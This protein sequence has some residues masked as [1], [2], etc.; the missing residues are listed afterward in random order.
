M[1]SAKKKLTRKAHAKLNLFL[2]VTGKLANGYHELYSLVVF[3]DLA[4]EITVESATTISVHENTYNSGITDN[5]IYKTAVK[6]A[7]KYDVRDGAKITFTKNIPIG[8]G[9]GGGS[10][11][12]ATTIF[13]LNN[14][15]DLNLHE[16]EMYKLA[17]ELGADVPVCLYSLLENKNSA[18]FKGIGEIIAPA[19]H[20]PK[21]SF[22]LVNPGIQLE[23]KKVFQSF[24]YEGL[25]YEPLKIKGDILT[26]I[27]QRSNDLEPP[28]IAIVPEIGTALDE[29]AQYKNCKLARMTGS[30]A[31]SFAIFEDHDDARAAAIDMIKKHPGW[32]IG[33]VGLKKT[34]NFTPFEKFKRHLLRK[35]VGASIFLRDS[36]L[37][38]ELR[39]LFSLLRVKSRWGSAFTL[40]LAVHLAAVSFHYTSF[41]DR[42]K[43]SD[44][45]F[46]TVAFAVENPPP[47]EEANLATAAGEP[48]EV[49]ETKPIEK[50]KPKIAKKKPAPKQV[51]KLAKKP[52]RLDAPKGT[53]IGNSIGT[54]KNAPADYLELLQ[55]AVQERSV[56]HNP[57]PNLKGKAVL[58]LVFN[59]RGYVL[60]YKLK[61][62]TGEAVL[63][64]AAEK[65]AKNLMDNPLPAAPEDFD[66]G[67]DI[68][69]YDFLVS[70]PP[71]NKSAKI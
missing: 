34:T 38:R 65:L 37:N 54:G 28:A 13:L 12:A 66:R 47:P 69:Q 59:R 51:A 10:A 7:Q 30:G 33:P 4:D 22:T 35:K 56:I 67:D 25:G 27:S 5:I 48:P 29:L 39:G 36:T 49:V 17:L 16:D 19:P 61:Q 46:I 43:P 24:A 15:W 55:Y 21:M 45:K 26:N 31:T 41:F 32:M 71:T 50:P 44:P 11:D 1:K 3:L 9:L 40:S 6:M 42:E 23:T 20:L 58:R 18:V 52:G 70:Y 68:L 57:D 8:G 62:R 60:T 53:P 2:E 63:D 14:L 64:R